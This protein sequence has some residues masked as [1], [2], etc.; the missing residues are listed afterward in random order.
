MYM[1]LKPWALNMHINMIKYNN[2]NLYTTAKK[3][4]VSSVTAMIFV[5]YVVYDAN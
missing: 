3:L 4:G 1:C 2:F 5:V